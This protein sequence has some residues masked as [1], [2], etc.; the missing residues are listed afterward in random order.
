MSKSLKN[1]ITIKQAL[2]DYSERQLRLLF[3]MHTWTDAIDYSVAT[4]ENVISFERTCNEF[5][6][7]VKDLQRHQAKA[8]KES[9]EAD[10]SG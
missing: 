2:H 8:C 10:V 4:M 1:F 9:E 7:N 5:F 6:L 3:L